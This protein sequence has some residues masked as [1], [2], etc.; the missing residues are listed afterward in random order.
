MQFSAPIWAAKG[1][2]VAGELKSKLARCW[3]L[4]DSFFSMFKSTLMF[5]LGCSCLCLWCPCDSNLSWNFLENQTGPG[6]SNIRYPFFRGP[7]ASKN[8]GVA[9][10]RWI[11]R[12]I[13]LGYIFGLLLQLVPYEDIKTTEWIAQKAAS[14]IP[15]IQSLLGSRNLSLLSSLPSNQLR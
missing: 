8:P 1:D 13:N 14:N 4:V 10:R 2:E 5:V 11:Q 15:I 12:G 6:L 9:I 7:K 3:S